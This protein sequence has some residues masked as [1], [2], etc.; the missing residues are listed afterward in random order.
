M[1]GGERKQIDWE[2][3]ER[4]YRVG[5]LSLRALAEKHG[6]TAS[7][8]SRRAAK[9]GWV[10]D[11][12]QE[13]RERTRAALLVAAD[14]GEEGWLIVRPGQLSYQL[15]C[16]GAE[17]RLLNENEASVDRSYFRYGYG[18]GPVVNGE[19]SPGGDGADH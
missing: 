15:P 2:A 11:A 10:Q 18:L 5:Q 6:T 14:E 1:A 7:T 13:V 17:R 4:D 9:H 3:V 12:S 16:S 8:I 19:P